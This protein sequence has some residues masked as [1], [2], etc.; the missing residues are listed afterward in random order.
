LGWDD[1]RI[2]E[3]INQV[4]ILASISGED[5]CLGVCVCNTD[6]TIWDARLGSQAH[7]EVVQ[8]SSAH[9]E[10]I[11]EVISSGAATID[12]GYV[13]TIRFNVDKC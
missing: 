10:G 13:E 1:A 8:S 2:D 5:I 6:Q 12:V 9:G 7:L 11:L 3:R 4:R